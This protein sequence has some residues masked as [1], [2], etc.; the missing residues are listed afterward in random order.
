MGSKQKQPSPDAIALA[1]RL[2]LD[3]AQAFAGA[4]TPNPPVGCTLLDSSGNVLAVAAHQRAGEGHA[5][6]LAI[7]ECQSRGLVEAIHTVVVS[8]EPCN[9]F[10]RT[11]PCSQAILSTPARAVWI[12]TR[13]PN[14][15]V[16]GG[17]SETLS[18]AGLEV[19]LIDDLR[20]AETPMLAADARRLVA[21]FVK[22]MRTGLPWVTVKQAVNASGS[23]IPPRGSK[24]FSSFSSLT[25]AHG[26]RRRADAMI[27]GSGTV[28]ADAPLFTVRHVAD[29]ADKHR[30]LVILDRRH[31]VPEHY[32][33]AARERGLV[34][35]IAEDFAGAI[36]Q[37][38]ALNALE[39]LVEAGPLVTTSVLTSM[40]WD[41]HVR[42]SVRNGQ[43][44]RV[45]ITQNPSVSIPVFERT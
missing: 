13:D 9:H 35:K 44:D 16:R 40:L 42:I 39:V 15:K 28:L 30:H 27:T 21:P 29:F 36:S 2:A 4:T 22:H 43:A 20:H 24:T 31:R 25:L 41:E 32:L 38:G 18:A 45:E 6:A 1:F 5:E 11:P 33:A 10:G 26:L 34:P 14:H 19:R 23:M 17:G 8:L 3:A 7:R 12:G 37:L